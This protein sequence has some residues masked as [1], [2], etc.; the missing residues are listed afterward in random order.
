MA[1]DSSIM[2]GIYPMYRL[3]T[4]ARRLGAD[5][6]T[7]GVLLPVWA[8]YDAGKWT[9]Y[10]GTGYRVNHGAG[11]RNSVFTGVT[12]LREIHEGFQ[13]GGEVFGETPTARDTGSTRGFNLGGILTLTPTINFL[14]SA[15]KTFGDVGSNLFYAGLQTHF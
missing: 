4:G 7:H 12:V 14:F 9:T 15:G 2:L 3:A 11:G 5:R 6:G 13:L 10:G 1:G 8:Q